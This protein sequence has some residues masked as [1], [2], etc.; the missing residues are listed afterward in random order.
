MRDQTRTWSVLF[1]V[2][3]LHQIWSQYFKRLQRKVRKTKFEQRAITPIK[4][5]QAW[6]Y[7]NLICI[8]RWQFHTPNLKSISLKKMQRKVRENLILAKDNNSYKS[9]SSVTKLELDLY[10]VMANSYIKC[11]VNISIDSREKSGKLKCDRLTDGRTDG[12]TDGLTD[13]R[14]DGRTDSEQ[15]KSPPAN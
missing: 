1:D 5:G 4:V 6:R 3:F 2:K 7:S 13:W 9:R 14:T 8:M 15:T 11:E 10:Y 12:R